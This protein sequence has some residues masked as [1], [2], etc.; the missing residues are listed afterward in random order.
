M[1]QTADSDPQPPTGSW[2]ESKMGSRQV[3]IWNGLDTQSH[4]SLDDGDSNGP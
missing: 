3:Y 4:H 1:A 2:S